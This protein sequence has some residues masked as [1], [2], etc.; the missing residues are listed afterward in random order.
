MTLRDKLKFWILLSSY[1]E[2]IVRGTSPLSL[3]DAIANSLEYL[4]AFG[5]TEQRNL[6][7]GYTELEYIQS[8]GTQYIDTGIV[9]TLSDTYE[10]ETT[11]NFA[12]FYPNV[13]K[14]FSALNNTSGAGRFQPVG[15]LN[16]KFIGGYGSNW[17][18]F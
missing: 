3:P 18:Y 13:V 6:P 5:G 16:N 15:Y 11:L 1:V 8:T 12:A 4:K 9:P 2:M 14:W 10:M 7:S 17:T